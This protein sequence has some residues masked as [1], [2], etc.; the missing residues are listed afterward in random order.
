MAA[1]TIF[2]KIPL[3]LS[4]ESSKPIEKRRRI[5]PISAS[6]SIPK[7]LTGKRG[8]K[9]RGTVGGILVVKT[10]NKKVTLSI[11]SST[12]EQFQQYCDGHAIML[13]KKVELWMNEEMNKKARRDVL[14][15]SHFLTLFYI[16]PLCFFSAL[17]Y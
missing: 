3:Y 10:A 1:S 11:D 6:L 9:K 15:I 5:D 16:I 2:V 13:S 17:F 14:K 8:K 4:I 12:Y 7:F